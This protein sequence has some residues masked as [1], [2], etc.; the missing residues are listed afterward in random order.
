MKRKNRAIIGSLF[1]IVFV[2]GYCIAIA[3]LAG[4]VMAEQHWAVQI[5]FFIFAGIV[6]APVL[7][8]FM[9]W[10]RKPD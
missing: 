3:T 6:W 10:V 8:P 9:L 4:P 7:R 1:L 5:A 2:F